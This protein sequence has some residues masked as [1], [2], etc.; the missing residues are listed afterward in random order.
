ML[1]AIFEQYDGN[2]KNN[3]KIFTYNLP[4]AF[5]GIIFFGM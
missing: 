1:R 2:D 5:T 4:K 3:I